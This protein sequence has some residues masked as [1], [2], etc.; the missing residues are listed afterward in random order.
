MVVQNDAL[1]AQ[2]F[3][4]LVHFCATAT[5]EWPAGFAPVA[6]VAVADGDE[7]NMMAALGPQ[8][9]TA[10]GLQFAIVWMRAETDDAE[11]VVLRWHLDALDASGCA[12]L[13]GNDGEVKNDK[14]CKR[15][16]K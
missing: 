2:D 15:S 3:M 8:H 1:N 12:A 6:D 5:G 7:Q 10:T 11:L 9:R 13:A 4:G 16:L 14:R